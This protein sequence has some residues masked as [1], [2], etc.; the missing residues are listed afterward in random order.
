MDRALLS[1]AAADSHHRYVQACLLRPF[2]RKRHWEALGFSCLG[3]YASERL[4]LRKRTV[5]E[6]ARVAAAMENVPMIRD[7]LLSR[8][9]HWTHARL[10]ATVATQ[11][12]AAA[13]LALAQSRT[14][15][16]LEK[17][18]KL[19]DAA[20]SAATSAA[21]RSEATGDAAIS[22]VAAD[23]APSNAT[24]DT[25][26]TGDDVRQTATGVHQ[27]DADDADAMIPWSVTC[28]RRGRQLFR[29]T[30][31]MASRVA[32]AHLPAWA[33]MEAIAAEAMA[34]VPP[35]TRASAVP[36]SHV[37]SRAQTEEA[38]RAAFEQR[39]GTADGF[40]WLERPAGCIRE[41]RTDPLLRDLDDCDAFELDARLRLT[42]RAAQQCDSKLGD[43]LRKLSD[44]DHFK[45]LGFATIDIYVRSRLGI[46]RSKAKAL[47]RLDR[48]ASSTSPALGNAY[49]DGEISTLA[50]T[51][52]LPVLGGEHDE[53][54]LDRARNFTHRSLVAQVGW[55]LDRMDDPQSSRQQP[56]PPADLDVIAD[57]LARVDRDDVQM[58]AQLDARPLPRTAHVGAK[59]AFDAP[60]SV[61]E[62]IE[63]AIEAYRQ[64][65]ERRWQAFERIVARA[66][67]TWTTLPKHRD[68]IF[69]RDSYRCSVPGCTR[70]AHLEDHH[71]RFR[72]H[73]GSNV[74]SNRTAVCYWHHRLAI[75]ERH[76]RA[77]GCA[78]DQIRWELGC[79]GRSRPL[80]C[81]VG[82]RYVYR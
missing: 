78:P 4:G 8:S 47:V 15:R 41:A 72:S 61:A 23:P 36:L 63:D 14:T 57:G 67:L 18:V 43:L 22:E 77:S 64:P 51:T 62:L 58:R 76:I 46:S 70:R 3:D 26:G 50:A 29:Q 59:I 38:I 34:A 37:R 80:I 9:I 21:A 74:R 66:F 2:I 20:L 13:W 6:D 48:Q 60:R 39:H 31:E 16:E 27:A 11:Q 42:R 56:P 44:T 28:S 35:G 5:E 45:A 17:L 68:P 71:L 1:A 10:L 24:G 81:T 75:H 7:A 73:G 79:R 53:A 12:T 52:L 49:R 40:S 82:D 65:G 69:A 19:G 55:A 32:G 54:W 30:R 25:V 33:A